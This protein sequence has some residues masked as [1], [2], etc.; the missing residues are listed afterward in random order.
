MSAILPSSATH[1]IEELGTAWVRKDLGPAGYLS[2][3]PVRPPFV[4]DPAREP[5][6]YREVLGPLGIGPR[7][8]YAGRDWVVLERVDAPALW[9]LGDPEVWAAVAGWVAHLHERLSGADTTRV[10][11]LVYDAAVFGAWRDRA[12][13]AGV[14]AGVLAAHERASEL[15][16]TLPPV[17]LHGDLYPS[18]LLVTAGPPVSVCPVDWEL[19]ARG[20]AALDVAAVTSG[21]WPA[22]RRDAF[23]AAYRA[24]A[25]AAGLDPGWDRA[26]DAARLHICIQWLGMP[27][28]WQPPAWE[29]HDWAGEASGLACRF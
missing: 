26:L 27:A 4:E 28:G 2:G 1:R 20:P 14:P 6:A 11:L 7:C 12:A 3:S 22:E 15:L 10:P 19:M 24:S 5:A 18:N 21:R 25:G 16:L 9:Q 17:V 8:A 23:V 13:Q 29:S